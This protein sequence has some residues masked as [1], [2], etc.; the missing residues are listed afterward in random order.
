M[1]IKHLLTVTLLVGVAA[2]TNAKTAT[3]ADFGNSKASL[4]RAQTANP[5]VLTNPAADPVTGVDP[6]YAGNVIE[7][8]RENVAK[9]EEVQ[10]PISIRVGGQQGSN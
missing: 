4:I 5:A 7:A 6:D 1:H 10:Q 2:C 3:E 8:M 9:P